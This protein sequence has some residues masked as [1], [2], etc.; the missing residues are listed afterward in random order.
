MR[1][2]ARVAFHLLNLM[3]GPVLILLMI[4]R[5]FFLLSF[6]VGILYLIAL[7]GPKRL[8]WLYVLFAFGGTFVCYGLARFYDR[9]LFRLNLE[10]AR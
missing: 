6:A 8:D 2:M 4:G 7:P 9:A 5:G 3:R 10:A 1:L